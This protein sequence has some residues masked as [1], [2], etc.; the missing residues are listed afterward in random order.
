MKRIP[1][2][3]TNSSNF[4][5]FQI[6]ICSNK[7]V[8]IPYALCTFDCV[9][10]FWRGLSEWLLSLFMPRTVWNKHIETTFELCPT[11]QKITMDAG[12]NEVAF[13]LACLHCPFTW[14][15]VWRVYQ[16]MPYQISSSQEKKNTICRFLMMENDP[17]MYK[18]CLTK[19]TAVLISTNGLKP[20]FRRQYVFFVYYHSQRAWQVSVVAYLFHADRFCTRMPF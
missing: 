19:S 16:S 17:A 3:Y 10:R 13:N 2:H 7:G 11:C 1:A 20:Q 18:L 8:I 5:C 12:N 14:H 9:F 4:T 6:C 15:L